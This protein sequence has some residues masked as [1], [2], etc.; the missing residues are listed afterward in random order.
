[1]TIF[2]REWGPLVRYDEGFLRIED[3]NPEVSTR[4]RLSRWELFCFALSMMRA[5]ILAKND[6]FA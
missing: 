2:W 6:D 4:W 1:M 5:A 3:L